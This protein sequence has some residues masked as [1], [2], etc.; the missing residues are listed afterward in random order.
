MEDERADAPR[1]RVVLCEIATGIVCKSDGS[2]WTAGRDPEDL[3]YAWFSTRA[4]AQA[5]LDRCCG[6]QPQLEGHLEAD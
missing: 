4:E 2:R 3:K 1:W 5:H 6:A